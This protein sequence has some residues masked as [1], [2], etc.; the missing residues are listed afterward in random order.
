MYVM[1]ENTP[2]RSILFMR[3]NSFYKNKERSKLNINDSP[4]HELLNVAE[5]L[6]K[7]STCFNMILNGHCYSKQDGNKFF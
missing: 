7:V 2:C 1:N 6:G 3:A 4:T 5:R